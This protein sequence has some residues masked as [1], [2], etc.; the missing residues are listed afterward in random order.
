VVKRQD[1]DLRYEELRKMFCRRG[2]FCQMLI[3]QQDCL[4]GAVKFILP[5]VDDA[6]KN[7][8]RNAIERIESLEATYKER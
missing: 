1:S 3:A 5:F 7:Y 4:L 2:E 6:M 8:L